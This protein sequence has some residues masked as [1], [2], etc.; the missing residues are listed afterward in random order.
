M[1]S[2]CSVRTRKSISRWKILDRLGV[3]ALKRGEMAG[4][5]VAA[6][7]EQALAAR[8]KRLLQLHRAAGRRVRRERIRAGAP[9]SARAAARTIRRWDSCSSARVEP[10]RR[11]R[12]NCARPMNSA[13]PI[14]AARAGVVRVDR[15]RAADARQ[16]PPPPAPCRPA[17]RR[18]RATRA[19]DSGCSSMARLR[20]TTALL[21]QLGHRQ[22]VGLGARMHAPSSMCA[23]AYAGIERDRAFEQ[24]HRAIERLV[25]LGAPVE[26]RRARTPRTLRRRRSLARR[27]LG[28]DSRARSVAA[29]S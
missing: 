22:I 18:A 29:S 8:Q 10:R 23:R 2:A 12:R 28:R 3:A 11:L 4:A 25:C 1:R 7:D 6:G 27:P 13:R 17:R 5:H 20:L 14:A 24:H 16:C 9:R 19:P 26:E 21:P 15:Q